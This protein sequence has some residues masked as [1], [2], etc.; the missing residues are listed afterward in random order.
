VR[1]GLVHRFPPSGHVS[2]SAK[3]VLRTYINRT[4]D[5]AAKFA[6]AAVAAGQTSSNATAIA[7]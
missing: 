7:D 6:D 1:T 4:I 5:F 2:S 3:E